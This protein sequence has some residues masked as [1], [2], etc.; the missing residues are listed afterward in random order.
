[1]IMTIMVLEQQTEKFLVF[2]KSKEYYN[3]NN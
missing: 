1:M 2:N 3:D